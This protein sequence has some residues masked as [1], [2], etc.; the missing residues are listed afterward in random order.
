MKKILFAL[1]SFALLACS[2]NGSSATSATTE[3]DTEKLWYFETGDFKGDYKNIDDYSSNG[4]KALNTLRESFH[5]V[6]TKTFNCVPISKVSDYFLSISEDNYH[7]YGTNALINRV[8]KYG[9]TIDFY[10]GK[11]N[12]FHYVYLE[13]CNDNR[14]MH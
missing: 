6:A 13:R 7:D 12:H 4:V 8:E 9:S 5:A 14:A 11:D 2:D 3:P 1:V 10:L